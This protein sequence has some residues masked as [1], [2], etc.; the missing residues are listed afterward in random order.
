MP[1]KSPICSCISCRKEY[2]AK[3]IHSHFLINHTAHGGD[4]IHQ[5]KPIT[6][7]NALRL[8]QLKQAKEEKYYLNP[9]Y[10]KECNEVISY[11]ATGSSF[12]SSSCAAVYNNRTRGDSGWK[13]SEE[14]KYK[15]SVANTKIYTAIRFYPCSQCH[16]TYMWD[17]ITRGSKSCCSSNDCVLSLDLCRKEQASQRAKDRGLGGVRPS[18]R[19]LYNNV[20]LGSSYEHKL[21]ISMDANNIS[22]IKPK[23]MPYIDPTG[24]QRTYEADFYLPD[25]NVY[26]DPKNNFLINN[27]NPRLGFSD[28]KKISLAMSYNNVK[29][30]ILNSEQLDWS[31]VVKL[32]G[33]VTI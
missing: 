26:L 25:Y 11:D 17:S 21:A 20:W 5:S 12:C 3:G 29:I 24:K 22:W 23:R 13:H 8:Q 6:P 9:K 31:E 2:T 15:T 30:I 1:I 27:I 16:K 7:K 33:S 32:I 18:N 4:H 28:C 10:C 19:I 14:S